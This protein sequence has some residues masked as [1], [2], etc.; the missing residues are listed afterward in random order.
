MHIWDKGNQELLS[1][2]RKIFAFQRKNSDTETSSLGKL[3][4][5]NN[6]WLPVNKQA[7]KPRIRNN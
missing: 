7:K 5:G 6:G 2:K 1:D 4:C 3:S